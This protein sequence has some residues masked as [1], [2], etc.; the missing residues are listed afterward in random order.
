MSPG[1]IQTSGTDVEDS[2]SNSLKPAGEPGPLL[3]LAANGTSD[4]TIVVPA[5]STAQEEKAAALVQHWLEQ[6]SGVALPVVKDS[7]AAHPHEISIGYTDRMVRANLE[8]YRDLGEEGYQIAVR[9]SRI[10]LVGGTRRGPINAALA[11]LEEDLGCR[12]YTPTAHRVEKRAVVEVGIVPRRFVPSLS[13]RDPFVFDAFNGTWSLMNRTNSHA[14]PVPQE[15]GGH[16]SYPPSWYVHTADAMVS[17]ELFDEHPEYFAEIDGKRRREREGRHPAQLCL[18]NPDVPR[19]AGESVLRVLAENPQARLLSVSPN[20]GGD[21]C[22]C[23]VCSAFNEAE[24]SDGATLLEFVNRVAEAIETKH[25][26][27]RVVHLA[28]LGTDRATKTIRPRDNVVVMFATDYDAWRWPFVP[29]SE[30][31]VTRRRLAPWSEM[32]AHVFVW[33]YVT[34]FSHYLLPMPNI[35][36]VEK[37]LRFLLDRG[38]EGI[39]LQGAYQSPGS[40]R[41]PLR[42]WVWAKKL[43]D[44]DR[45]V[46]ALVRDFTDG[47]FEAAAPP[48][49]AYNELLDRVHEAQFD[50]FV[51]E[52]ES[53]HEIR[54]NIR[55]KPNAFIDADFLNAASSLFEDA[56]RLASSDEILARVTL[57]KLSILYAKLTLGPG[58]TNDDYDALIGEFETIARSENVTHLREGAPDVDEKISAW[59]R[60]YESYLKSN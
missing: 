54:Y 43:W 55:Y 2:W 52:Y 25:P 41:G 29:Y 9:E 20:D 27:V 35:P 57:A 12:W 21:Y 47:Y 33:D 8:Q 24:Q 28:Y 59:R 6:M 39:F 14:A 30:T 7:T 17:L 51:A 46:A 26:H 60:N 48:L 3:L 34:N 38:A 37:N 36:I 19:L 49:R 11:L 32:G 23:S 18:T 53:A 5:K 15:L 40:A 42:A 44:P 56:E 10:F 16:L 45:E 1:S 58:Y 31:E 22:Q 13:L 4:Y 50:R